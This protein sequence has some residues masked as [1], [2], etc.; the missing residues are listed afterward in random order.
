MM[1]V[2]V[3][4]FLPFS[5]IILMLFLN[6]AGLSL[7]FCV[8]IRACFYCNVRI[9]ALGNTCWC[10]NCPKNNKLQKSWYKLNITVEDNTEKVIFMIFGKT[11]QLLIGVDALEIANNP[12]MTVS[13]LYHN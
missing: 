12:I 3:F 6:Y 8:S 10:T 13:H 9:S 11:T 7:S 4:M 2:E 5:D 1:P